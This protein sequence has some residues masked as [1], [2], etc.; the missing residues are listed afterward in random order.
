MT[1]TQQLKRDRKG[2][3][4]T[5]SSSTASSRVSKNEPQ[6]TSAVHSAFHSPPEPMKKDELD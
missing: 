4:V 2:I 5:L 3:R 6:K 1:E